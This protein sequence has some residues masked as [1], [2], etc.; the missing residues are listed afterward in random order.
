MT[1]EMFASRLN[2]VLDRLNFPQC[3]NDRELTF[4]EY[5]DIAQP[6][7]KMILAG[8]VMP[9]RTMIDRIADALFIDAEQLVAE[10]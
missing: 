5:F 10:A 3:A 2:K 1:S 7:A 9:K 6:K 8:T 4:C